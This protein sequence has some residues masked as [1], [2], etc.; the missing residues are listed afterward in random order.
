M[1]TTKLISW[2]DDF[3]L[4]VAE[5]DHEHRQLIDVMNQLYQE[6]LLP[7][8]EGDVSGFLAELEMH[9]SAHFAL[10]ERL[11]Q[12]H[13]YAEY[14]DHKQDHERLLNQIRDLMDEYEDGVWVDMKAFSSA[15][16]DWFS[17][18]FSTFDARLHRQLG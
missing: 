16:A 9:I 18:H 7:N 2:R 5:V 4:G 13:G 17:S 6:M 14:A 11:M 3:A 10:E 1:I 12:A 8:D 15:L